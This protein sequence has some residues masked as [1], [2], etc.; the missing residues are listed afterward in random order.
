MGGDA[1]AGGTGANASKAKVQ[2]T[3]VGIHQFFM[4]KKAGKKL[5]EF[6]S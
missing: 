2:T 6:T 4:V 5:I 3:N 1:G